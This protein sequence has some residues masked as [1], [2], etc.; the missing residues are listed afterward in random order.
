M[1]VTFRIQFSPDDV[2][3]YSEDLVC[4][5]DREKFV[6]PLLSNLLSMLSPPPMFTVD[7]KNIASYS[8]SFCSNI[9]T[10]TPLLA[11]GPRTRNR[12]A[13]CS[14][15]ARYHCIPHHYREA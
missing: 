8:T 7:Q 4:I 15:P 5:T 14:G 10:T 11:V 2:K 1:D 6:V 12:C 13:C 3:D 9:L